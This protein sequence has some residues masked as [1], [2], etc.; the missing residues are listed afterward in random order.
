MEINKSKTVSFKP[1]PSSDLQYSLNTPTA[2]ISSGYMANT[3]SYGE[4][5]IL[6]GQLSI[7]LQASSTPADIHT[8]TLRRGLLSVSSAGSRKV[9]FHKSPTPMM[10]GFIS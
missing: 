1:T 5:R 9:L 3:G 7:N 6:Y 2:Q 8:H 10:Q 4:P